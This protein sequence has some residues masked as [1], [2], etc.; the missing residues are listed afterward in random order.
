MKLNLFFA[1][2]LVCLL[3]LSCTAQTS[4]TIVKDDVKPAAAT[5]KKVSPA[6][7]ML[8]WDNDF[9]EYG[10]VK[11]GD[12]REHTY[13]FQNISKE[14]V[15]IM[16]CTA[17]DCTTLDWTTKT[18]KPGEYGEVNT[19]FNSR[20]KDK[21]ETINITIILKNEDAILHYPIVD[22]IKFHFEIEK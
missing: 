22:E 5:E 14:D 2:F 15:N 18:I 4:K 9:I 19:I 10:K 20:D 6:R 3:T 7:Q 1:S 17:C 16:I 12:K 11:K 8:K 21:D 13:K